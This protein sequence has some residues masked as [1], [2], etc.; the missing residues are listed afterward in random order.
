MP[1]GIYTLLVELPTTC[2][3][4]VG[5]LGDRDFAAG[6]YAYTGSA[7]GPG[8]LAR[9]DR[10][11]ELATGE[12][13]ARHWHI[14]Y[15]LGADQTRLDGVWYTTETEAECQVARTLPGERVAE[16]GASDCDC[17]G[18][19]AYLPTRDPLAETLTDVHECQ[20][21]DSR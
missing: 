19:L 20:G 2:R 7:H 21:I 9:I 8:G 18:H 13:S 1:G 15:L 4:T 11:R 12:R 5:A 14:D 17:V 6:W 3:L 10:H 16:F